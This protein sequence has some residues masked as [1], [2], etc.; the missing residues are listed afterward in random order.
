MPP[1]DLIYL[2]T[3]FGLA[4]LLGF[5]IGLERELRQDK[6]VTLGIRDFILF[7]LLGA[8]AGYVALEYQSAWFLGVALVGVLALV[9][10]SYWAE[11]DHGPGITTEL[12]ALAIFLVGALLVRGHESLGIALA[13]LVVTVL[14]RKQAIKHFRSKV[15]VAEMRAVLMFLVI[16]FIILPVLPKQSLDLYLSFPVGEVEATDAAA[17][18]VEIRLEPTTTVE[19]GQALLLLDSRWRLRATAVVSQVADGKAEARLDHLEPGLLRPGLMARGRFALGPLNVMLSALQPYKIWLIVVLVSFISFVGYVLIRILGTRAGIGLTGLIGGLV[20][21]TVT[22]LAFARRSKETPK[23]NALLAMAVILAASIM[24]PRVV[25]ELAVVNQQI[26]KHV[27]LPMMV[28]CGTGAL[29]AVI[30]YWRASRPAHQRSYPLSFDNPFSL[31]AAITFALVFASILM[32]TRLATAYLGGGWLPVVSVV[33]GLT[34]AD[35]IAFS[36]SDLHKAGLVS[37]DWA[38]FN[39]VLGAISNTFMKLLLILGLGDRGLF[40][41]VLVGFLVM[42]GTGLVT[43]FLYYF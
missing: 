16:T 10:S 34:D 18:T 5:L 29:V 6:R 22:T 25:V 43:A 36:L 31:R 20:S 13:I 15:Q 11:R 19:V 2:F 26:M 14:F 38:G 35:A 3:R 21:S 23:A 1:D 42:S 17:G 7:A 12:A 33:S 4:A 28:M 30:L 32:V 39:L 24:F 27:A 40:R 37:L 9:L 8:M 41:R